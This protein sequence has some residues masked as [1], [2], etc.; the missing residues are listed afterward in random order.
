[1]KSPIR[2]RRMSSRRRKSPRRISS[3]RRKSPRRMS[4]RRRKSPRR[5]SSRRRKSPRR[6]SSRRLQYGGGN[7][8]LCNS[9]NTRRDTCPLNKDAKKPN[10]KKHPNAATLQELMN[11][12]IQGVQRNEGRQ[13]LQGRQ[14]V[15]ARQGLQARQGVQAPPVEIFP[16][17]NN[18]RNRL[19]LI[20]QARNAL[21]NTNYNQAQRLLQRLERLQISQPEQTVQQAPRTL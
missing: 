6:M 18:R 2:K 19:S 3:R 1:M 5:M 12:L 4:S 10:P 21:T 11:D 17:Q 14:G 9:P 16:T 20:S 8:T 7:C 15:Q 13:G